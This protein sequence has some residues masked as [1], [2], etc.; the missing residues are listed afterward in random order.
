MGAGTSLGSG[1]S[2]D[3][4]AGSVISDGAEAE[5]IVAGAGSTG[6]VGDIRNV[7]SMGGSMIGDAS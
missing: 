4:G 5:S 2:T 7:G 6:E 3:E 1:T